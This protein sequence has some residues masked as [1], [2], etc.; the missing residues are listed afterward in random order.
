[1][2]VEAMLCL[3][4]PLVAL[5]IWLIK[6]SALD[7]VKFTTVASADTFDLKTNAFASLIVTGVI[8]SYV[9]MSRDSQLAGVFF[10]RLSRHSVSLC[11]C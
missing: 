8:D 5:V 2:P 7:D 4:V 1:M 10:T 9:H 6:L 11:R 3:N